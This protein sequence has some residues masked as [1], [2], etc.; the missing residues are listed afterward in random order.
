M[1]VCWQGIKWRWLRQLW[2][3]LGVLHAHARVWWVVM[4]QYLSGGGGGVQVRYVS[5]TLYGAEL[6][7]MW[8]VATSVKTVFNCPRI[9]LHVSIFLRSNLLTAT[10]L[11][12]AI[13]VPFLGQ[14]SLHPSFFF[15][16]HANCWMWFVDFFF[17]MI[18]RI[19]TFL[20]GQCC[21]SC[22]P[23]ESDKC[24]RS[25]FLLTK[26]VL[27]SQKM[28]SYILVLLLCYGEKQNW[29]RL[30]QMCVPHSGS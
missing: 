29:S 1:Q 28:M 25:I 21:I 27:M 6:S 16:S 17:L 9:F 5:W 13:E 30:K 26:K 19:L 23:H 11:Q 12:R 24:Y 18:I 7:K 4:C 15:Y 8:R 14:I 3:T 2:L 20:L 10:N 22:S